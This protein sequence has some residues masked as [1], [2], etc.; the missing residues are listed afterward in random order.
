MN[1]SADNC[2]PIVIAGFGFMGQTHAQCLAMNSRATVVGIVDADPAS[3]AAR[4]AQL[5]LCATVGSTL[6]E[7]LPQVNAA[8]VD[9]CLPTDLHRKQAET[10]FARKLHVFCEK[11]L[12]LTLE[13][14]EAMV[15]GA[16]KAGV[17]LMVGHCIR[18]WPEYRELERV[19][20][21]GEMGSLLALALT[22]RSGRP[23]YAVGD[24]V[25]DPSRCLGGALDLHIHDADFLN[26]LLGLP[27][28]VTSS[29]VRYASGWDHI[30][31]LYDYGGPCISAG[32]GWDH[33]A[34]W[35]F[36]MEFHAVFEGGTLD[37]D[38]FSSPT[39]QRCEA[40][41]KPQSVTLPALAAPAPVGLGAYAAELDYFVSCVERGEPPQV[42]TGEQAA[43]SLRLV[44]AEIESATSGQTVNL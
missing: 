14:A 35:G 9:L 12:A 38:S 30:E 29:G 18:F 20:R 41:G 19:V 24:W 21:R 33:P 2:V 37:F 44:L 13:D 7:V 26:H 23:G 28:A 39:L 10:A 17:F 4:A 25:A 15:R 34:G 42:A 3:A 32:G 8:I 5:G 36:R 16:E 1:R 27:A 6:E 43:Q 31:T 11:P 22:R 40:D